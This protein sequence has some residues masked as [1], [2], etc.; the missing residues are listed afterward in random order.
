MTQHFNDRLWLQI[1]LSRNDKPTPN[2]SACDERKNNIDGF[3]TSVR[4]SINR[5]TVVIPTSRRLG[6]FSVLLHDTHCPVRKPK[7]RRKDQNGSSGVLSGDVAHRKD[8]DGLVVGI[9]VSKYIEHLGVPPSSCLLRL[10]CTIVITY[11]IDVVRSFDVV[12]WA[13]NPA[14]TISCLKMFENAWIVRNGYY[15]RYE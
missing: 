12:S 7:E 2:L 11:H 8:D 4:R 10:Y 14:H 3:Y 6:R 13:W 1:H 15:S 5:G 9:S